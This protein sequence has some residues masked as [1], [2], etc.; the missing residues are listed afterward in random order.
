MMHTTNSIDAAHRP[1][2]PGGADICH[3]LLATLMKI[4]IISILPKWVHINN[5]K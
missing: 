4:N 3:L 5:Y 2:P 1:L